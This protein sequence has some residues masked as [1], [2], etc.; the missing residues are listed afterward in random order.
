MDA[1]VMVQE[2]GLVVVSRPAYGKSKTRGKAHSI[3]HG[4]LGL[5]SSNQE[6]VKS[7][8]HSDH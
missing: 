5:P 4:V 8:Y 6:G 7:A 3:I 1:S 2:C